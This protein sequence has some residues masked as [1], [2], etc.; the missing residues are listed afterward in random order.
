MAQLR[1]LYFVNS[2]F[3]IHDTSNTAKCVGSSVG[4]SYILI[5]IITHLLHRR[6]VN[7]SLLWNG[8]A[9]SKSKK[10]NPFGFRMF[11]FV[12]ETERTGLQC[13][14]YFILWHQSG[15]QAVK[16]DPVKLT[17]QN[18]VDVQSWYSYSPI[19]NLDLI[20]ASSHLPSQLPS[21]PATEPGA[22]SALKTIAG[23]IGEG[24]RAS[25]QSALDVLVKDV[26]FV[27]PLL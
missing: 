20:L 17:E 4:T 12:W 9:P 11:V 8:I 22:G 24:A 14:T 21:L 10:L 16:M 26:K 1:S 13:Y 15:M 5:I 18:Q 25:G 7:I 2:I 3:G 19:A 27:Q 23:D 6:P